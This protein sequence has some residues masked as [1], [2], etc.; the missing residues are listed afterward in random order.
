MPKRSSGSKT[1]AVPHVPSGRGRAALD[2]LGQVPWKD[3]KH[4]YTGVMAPLVASQPVPG[5]DVAAILR[6]LW[7]PDPELREEGYLGG[8]IST[9]WHQ[10]TIYE[11]TAFAI[12]FLAAFAADS[13]LPSRGRVLTALVL[14]ARS[15]VWGRAEPV[16]A[17]TLEALR[18]SRQFLEQLAADS[19]DLAA[20]AGR[21]LLGVADGDEEALEGAAELAEELE[22]WGDEEQVPEE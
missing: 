16:A 18:A 15:A 6:S 17:S 14:I 19:H 10:G 4:A 2:E 8:V 21:V 12:P 1:S 7:D 11:A 9:L 20:E 3:L 5:D 13:S 22:A